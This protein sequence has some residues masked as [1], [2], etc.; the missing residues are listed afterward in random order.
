VLFVLKIVTCATAGFPGF[1]YHRTMANKWDDVLQ[2]INDDLRAFWGLWSTVVLPRLDPNIPTDWETMK[3]WNGDGV[4]MAKVWYETEKL[5]EQVKK[6]ID[7]RQT[8]PGEERNWGCLNGLV[9]CRYFPS[10]K[11]TFQMFV[12][13]IIAFEKTPGLAY[14]MPVN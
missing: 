4:D 8:K 2:A 6:L 5:Q 1:D 13:R 7:E 11:T 9:T 3:A 10:N 12:Y 14:P